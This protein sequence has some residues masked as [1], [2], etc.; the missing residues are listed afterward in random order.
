M[1]VSASYIVWRQFVSLIV[2]EAMH[3][4]YSMDA[5]ALET[6]DLEISCKRRVEVAGLRAQEVLVK[7]PYTVAT[8]DLAVC[9]LARVEE[10]EMD[11]GMPSQQV[12][13]FD[14]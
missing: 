3:I 14:F 1:L 6:T 13:Y 8:L 4:L 9:K 10:T 12:R 5:M 11:G 7:L 2:S